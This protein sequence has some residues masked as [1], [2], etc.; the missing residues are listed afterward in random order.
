MNANVLPR[1]WSA[2]AVVVALAALGVAVALAGPGVTA[3]GPRGPTN[4]TRTAATDV[5]T[6]ASDAETPTARATTRTEESGPR[7]SSRLIAEGTGNATRV[8]VVDSGRPG[9]TAVVVGGMH[10]NERA[11][12]ETAHDVVSWEVT[13]GTLVV[14]PEAN[15]GAVAART[16][17]YRGVNL[18]NQFPVGERPRTPLARAVWHTLV[19]YDA[20]VVVDLH[21]SRGVYHAPAGVPSG[22][23]QA[24]FPTVTG[25]ARWDAN[26]AV[27]RVNDRYGLR[28]DPPYQ[29]NR[30][31]LL[32]GSGVRLVRKVAGDLNETGFIVET[33]QYRT[34]L[35][36]RVAWTKTVLRALLSRHGVV[37]ERPP[38][39]E[40]QDEN[41]DRSEDGGER[42]AALRRRPGR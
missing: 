28:D 40:E 11:G 25:T 24:V 19:R 2:V 31:N 35:E 27:G 6:T 3:P 18:N 30:G 7:V 21:S 15:P 5:P 9:P 20:D 36:T 37:P 8:Y 41:E 42:R 10:G 1:G 12:Y 13:R 16:R 33:T 29:F 32:Y 34:D 14:V 26:H 4:G 39:D 38:P 17:S 23:G 22:V